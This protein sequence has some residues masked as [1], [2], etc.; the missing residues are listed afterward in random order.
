[1]NARR[2]VLS[3]SR[4]VE[5]ASQPELAK[6]MGCP[7]PLWLRAA[8]KELIDNS[9]DHLEEN[10]VEAPSIAITVDADT[11]AVT[12]NGRGMA[13]ELVERLCIRSERTSTREAYAAP[14]R[15]SQGNA[16]P[17]LMALPLGLGRDEAVTTI[18]SC[19]V[20]HTIRLKVNRLEGRIDVE[21]VE[22][23]VPTT[24]GTTVTIARPPGSSSLAG[25][26]INEVCELVYR[27]ALINRHAEFRLRLA[28]GY[29]WWSGEGIP[30]AKWT[31]GMPVPAHWYS[32]ERF[33][34]R[35]LLEIRNNPKITVA[36]FLGTFK[37]LSSR[38]MRSQVAEDA[39]LSPTS[40]WRRSW[41]P[42]GPR[43][44]GNAPCGCSTQWRLPA[45]RP[46]TPC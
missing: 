26:D 24:P 2:S 6:R 11:L 46:S 38:T 5:F 25:S 19:G 34:H 12:D 1:M 10:D 29:E 44:T 32:L 22:R 15:G 17:V 36:Q 42:P 7:P 43:S 4:D 31:P 9:L 41:T 40:R 20:E 30:V 37:G 16:L 27:H 23:A 28:D 13:R 33:E 21:R 35:V 18:C 39:G 3:F 14:D 45:G 8:L